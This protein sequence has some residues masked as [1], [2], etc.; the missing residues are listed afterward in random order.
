MG[1]C[2]SLKMTDASRFKPKG[3]LPMPLTSTTY[4]SM[5]KPSE[6]CDDIFKTQ[7]VIQA[8]LKS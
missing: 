2:S 1:N 3:S 8:E 4:F 5:V 7:K 6:F